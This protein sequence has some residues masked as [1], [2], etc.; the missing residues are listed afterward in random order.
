RREERPRKSPA[1]QG[2]SSSRGPNHIPG[3]VVQPLP[4][5]QAKVQRPP[6]RAATLRRPRLTQ[7]LEENL[8]RRVIL[9]TAEAGYGKTTLLDDYHLVDGVPDI[10]EFMKGL[11][12]RAPVGLTLIIAGRR[13][14]S[15][16]L[17]RLRAM[18]EVADLRSDDLR[19]QP[20]ETDRLFR[21]TYRREIDADIV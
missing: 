12:A 8:H 19:F 13:A 7:W 6:L 5:Q 20:A 16:P 14:P 10:R 3:R 15:V 4:I 17:S 2:R 18:G 11:V 21:E 1:S 9:V